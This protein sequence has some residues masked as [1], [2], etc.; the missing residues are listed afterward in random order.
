M[1]EIKTR[2]LFHIALQP[3][4]QQ[5]VG[6]TPSAERRIAPFLGGEFEGERARGVIL[7]TP[8]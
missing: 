7:N 4:Q 5:I 6:G 2:H 8:G 3:G 1:S